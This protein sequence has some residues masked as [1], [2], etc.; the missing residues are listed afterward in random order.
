MQPLA[1]QFWMDGA[2]HIN[3]SPLPFEILK[4][5]TD[6]LFWEWFHVE[7]KT[8]H[9][10]TGTVEE[11]KKFW[12]DNVFTAVVPETD[13]ADDLTMEIIGSL[14]GMFGNKSVK[15]SFGDE[16]IMEQCLAGDPTKVGKGLM[17][18]SINRGKLILKPS[19]SNPRVKRW[20]RLHG[21]LPPE[22][23]S[24]KPKGLKYYAN[25][26]QFTTNYAKS[27]SFQRW[28]HI[29]LTLTD[30]PPKGLK[31]SL[32]EK[33]KTPHYINGTVK[34]PLLSGGGKE[35]VRAYFDLLIHEILH[36]KLEMYFE[37]E[38]M[39]FSYDEK[40]KWVAENSAG[41]M[42]KVA[43]HLTNY[44]TKNWKRA[45]EYIDALRQRLGTKKSMTWSG[46][47][48]RKRYKFQGMDISIE[49]PAGTLREGKDPDGKK[50]RS[51][52]HFDYGYIRK[53]CGVDKDH[54]DC[55]IGANKDSDKVFVIHQ[56]HVK[57]GKYDEDKVML[58]W[59]TKTEAV[60]D[61][62]KNY[63]RSDMYSGVSVMGMDEFKKKAYAT[64]KNPMMIKSK[65]KRTQ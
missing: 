1:I 36:H 6:I 52:L 9:I 44:E 60:R 30:T 14:L 26:S 53:T 27:T 4:K 34:L 50:W 65:I 39:N 23:M 40:E 61:Y 17:D 3:F 45:A 22:W 16:A 28:A 2:G 18:K 59:L 63:N 31:F 54:V 48:I 20:Q 51:L 19:P 24:S 8:G 25:P 46:H 55:F 35:N 29:A 15:K 37:T 32:S 49:S 11:I 47:P 10:P 21:E 33:H 57:T 7:V 56:K 43:P 5:P 58:G 42:D 12:Y 64:A 38:A 41:L 13:E 62:L